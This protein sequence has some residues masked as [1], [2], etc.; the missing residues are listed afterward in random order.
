MRA[1]CWHDKLD[2]RVERVPDPKI[3]NPRDAIEVTF[4]YYVTGNFGSARSATAT[5]AVL[6]DARS[7]I[8]ITS[9][10]KDVSTN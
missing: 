6:Y 3:L 5:L 2:V 10:I 9:A 8:R 7:G 4:P 1:V